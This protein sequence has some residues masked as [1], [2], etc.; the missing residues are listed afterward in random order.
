MPIGLMPLV[1]NA[2]VSRNAGVVGLA[3]FET[4]DDLKALER[5]RDLHAS[6]RIKILL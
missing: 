6:S 4:H 2:T 5:A 3:A 1:L